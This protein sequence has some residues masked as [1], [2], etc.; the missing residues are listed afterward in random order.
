MSDNRMPVPLHPL[1]E[2]ARPVCPVCGTTSYSRNGIHPQCAQTQADGRRMT[3]LKSAKNHAATKA[4]VRNPLALS[5]WHKRCPRC[6]AE[7]HI[8]KATCDCGHKFDNTRR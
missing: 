6:K 2:T 3:R 4:K 1:A 5:P 7:L 8:R